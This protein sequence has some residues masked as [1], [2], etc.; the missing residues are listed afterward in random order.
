[1]TG[2]RRRSGPSARATDRV[3]SPP[4]GTPRDPPPTGR[5]LGI[6]VG[7][8]RIGLAVSDPSQTIA[9]PLA[10]LTRRAGKRFP[11]VR[12]AP[13]LTGVAGVVVGLPL[14]PEG[15]EGARAAEARAVAADITRRFELPVAVWD[16]RFTTARAL[17]TARELGA[18]VRDRRDEIDRIAATVLLQQ[19]LE[20]R[21]GGHA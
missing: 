3:P 18:R 19:F 6:D 13:H 20:A 9:Q 14:T 4:S 11:F 15:I 16:E 10:T 5:L 7:D 12:L 2:G 21:R 17:T 1:M 8:R